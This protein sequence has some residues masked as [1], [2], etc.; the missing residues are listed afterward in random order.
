MIAAHHCKEAAMDRLA[1]LAADLDRILR[2]LRE[3]SERREFKRLAAP[4]AWLD[5]A[6]GWLRHE[7]A[8]ALQSDPV[9][10]DP[11]PFTFIPASLHN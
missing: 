1:D 6:N 7:L 10:P 2:E 4:L 3:E 9:A 11:V 8:R 5:E